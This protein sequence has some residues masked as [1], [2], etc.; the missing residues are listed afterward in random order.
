MYTTYLESF[1]IQFAKKKCI[2]REIIHIET[3]QLSKENVTIC[4]C[5]E[6]SV[7]P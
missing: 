2:F 3:L 4:K 7:D 6:A 5:L 1:K